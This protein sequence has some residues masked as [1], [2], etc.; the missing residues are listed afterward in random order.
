GEHGLEQVIAAGRA[1]RAQ[2]PAAFRAR[3]AAVDAGDLATIIYTSGTTGEPKGAMLSHANIAFDVES[4]LVVMAL[5]SDDVSLS[6]L[7]LSHI[8][9]RMAGL[10]SMLAAG[11]T[12]AYAESMDAVALDA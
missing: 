10:Y 4:C 1:R 2:D 3:A 6:F 7:P 12:I 9:E 8:F 5:R 11:V